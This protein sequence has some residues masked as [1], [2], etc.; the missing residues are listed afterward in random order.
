MW[1]TFVPAPRV[2]RL[3]DEVADLQELARRYEERIQL[4]EKRAETQSTLLRS[5]FAEVESI[6]DRLERI[7]EALND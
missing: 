3:E 5:M 7:R 4:L 2:E 1:I 6:H